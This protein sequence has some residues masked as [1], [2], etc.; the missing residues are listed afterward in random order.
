MNLLVRLLIIW[1]VI[2]WTVCLSV[3][4]LLKRQRSITSIGSIGAHVY[5]WFFSTL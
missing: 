1:M 3:C 4:N 5:L 2:Y